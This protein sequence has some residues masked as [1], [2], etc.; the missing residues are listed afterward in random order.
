MELNSINISINGIDLFEKLSDSNNLYRDYFIVN[1]V[2]GRRLTGLES[3][4]T[5][6][7]GM[8]GAYVTGYTKPVRPLFI[9]LTTKAPDRSRLNEKIERFNESINDR[10]VL[11]IRCDDEG[12]KVYFGVIDNDNDENESGNIYQASISVMCAD[13]FNY[14][15]EITLEL[16]ADIT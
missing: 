9:R 16:P 14:S 11:E 10:E 4:L 6:A 12:D 2:E 13:H 8:D 1:S 15:D 7:E 3:T 5:S